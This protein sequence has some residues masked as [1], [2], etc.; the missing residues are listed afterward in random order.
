M[1]LELLCQQIECADGGHDERPGD[2][3]PLMFCAYRRSTQGFKSSPQKLD[4]MISPWPR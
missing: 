2:D 3:A 1:G 4:N